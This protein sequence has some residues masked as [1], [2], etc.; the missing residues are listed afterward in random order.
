MASVSLKSIDT[1][2]VHMCENFK[3][4]SGSKKKPEVVCLLN[5]K[6]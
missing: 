6:P 5:N 3:K 1:L 2:H 4:A